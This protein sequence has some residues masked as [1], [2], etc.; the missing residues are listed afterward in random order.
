MSA[1]RSV[2]V[3]GA[4]GHGKVVAAVARAMGWA[5]LGYVDRDDAKRGLQVRDG[6]SAVVLAEAELDRATLAEWQRTRGLTAV[7][8]G[9]GDNRSRLACLSRIAETLATPAIHPSAVLHS[10]EPLGLGTVVCA[11]TVI[12]PGASIGR[13]VIVNTGA[14]VEHDCVLGDGSHL[15]SGAVLTG[16]VR[17]GKRTLVGAGSVVLPGISIGDDAIV[18]AGAVVHR[19]VP[20]GVSVVGNPAR[21]LGGDR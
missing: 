6:G 13:A 15:S 19:D 12:Q 18:G 1:E 5:V 11:G 7:L 21:P 3:W 4:G 17:V 2:L 10:S 14:I 16:G 20:D 9:I 8:L